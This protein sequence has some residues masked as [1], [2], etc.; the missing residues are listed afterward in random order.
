[1]ASRLNVKAGSVSLTRHTSARAISRMQTRHGKSRPAVV[2]AFSSGNP[3][4]RQPMMN[5]SGPISIAVLDM[6]V[7]ARTG[8]LPQMQGVDHHGGQPTERTPPA[9]FRTRVLENDAPE[10]AGGTIGWIRH[11]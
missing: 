11:I 5:S 2:S 8:F 7:P 1:M 6:R 10:F 4:I 9:V 3:T